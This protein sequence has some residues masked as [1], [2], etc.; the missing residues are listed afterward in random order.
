[1]ILAAGRGNRMRPL[2]DQVPKPLLKVGGKALIVWHLENLAK[3][4][5]TDVVINHAYLGRQIEEALG[6]GAQWNL[7]IQYSAEGTALETAGGIA[8]AL[9]Y[10]GNE[11]FLVVNGDVFIDIHFSQLVGVLQPGKLGHLMMVD[12]P[13]QHPQGD[14]AFSNGELSLQGEPKLTFSGVAVYHPSLFTE[15]TLGQVVKLAPLL[16]QAISQGLVTAEHHR[17]SWH[18]VGT[19]ERLYELDR[20]L[21]DQQQS[22]TIT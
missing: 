2:T 4:G 14:F 21:T 20:Q 5:F 12:N 6:N 19:P 17:G 3:A 9:P 16:Q 13:P 15:I 10:L 11:P 1:M 18:D 7:S 8:K 22:Q